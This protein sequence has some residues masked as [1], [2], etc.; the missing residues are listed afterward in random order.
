MTM[1]FDEAFE[2]LIGHE[3]GFQNDPNDPGNW[4]G[5]KVG[6][7]KL[8]GTK[9]GIAAN[10]YPGEDIPNLTLDRAK[11]LYKRDFWAQAGAEVVDDVLKFDVFDTAVNSGARQALKFLQRSADMPAY[12]VDGKLGPKTVMA[13]QSANPYRLL[14]RFNGHRLDFLNNLPLWKRCH[15]GWSQRIANNLMAA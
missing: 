1:N 5:G 7:G 3:G 15:E 6:A 10:T 13:L 8:L 14:L 9:Y 12:E 4:T 11:Y 2:R